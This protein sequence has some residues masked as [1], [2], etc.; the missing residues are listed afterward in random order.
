MAAV[1]LSSSAGFLDR[2]TMKTMYTFLLN[3]LTNNWRKV[4]AF[5]TE[6][7]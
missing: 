1:A 5:I 6:R 3:W 7:K 2:H 4:R